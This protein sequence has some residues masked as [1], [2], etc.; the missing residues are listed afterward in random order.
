MH[1]YKHFSRGAFF[2]NGL[3]S[4]LKYSNGDCAR[5]SLASDLRFCYKATTVYSIVKKII[6]LLIFLVNQNITTINGL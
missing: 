6:S 5:F 4:L 3:P 1:L 2:C